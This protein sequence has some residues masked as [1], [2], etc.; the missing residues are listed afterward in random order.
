MQPLWLVT[1]DF[2]RDGKLDIA[3]S[4]LGA[5]AFVLF[6]NGD[7]TFRP[8]KQLGSAAGGDQIAIGDFNG[9]GKPDIVVS[10]CRFQ[11][12]GD[13]GD[14]VTILLNVTKQNAPGQP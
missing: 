10:D 6:G 13:V 12:N 8:A 11:D 9:D 3:A 2:N 14:A 5:N 7:G 4:A 1:S